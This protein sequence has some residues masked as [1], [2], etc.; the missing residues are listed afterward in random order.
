[1]TSLGRHSVS[2]EGVL[3]APP[4]SLKYNC[5]FNEYDGFVLFFSG[6]RN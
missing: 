4:P 5:S 2:I 1:M 3:P 6:T